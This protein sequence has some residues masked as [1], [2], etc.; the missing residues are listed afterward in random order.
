MISLCCCS[1]IL[2]MVLSVLGTVMLI[3]GSTASFAGAL[4]SL[5]DLFSEAH[6]YDPD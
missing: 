5:P 3:I 2:G 6:W 1:Y 4:S